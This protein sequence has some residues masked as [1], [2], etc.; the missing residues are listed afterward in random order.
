MIMSGGHFDYKQCLFIDIAYKIQSLIDDN[1]G[2]NQYGDTIGRGYRSQTIE[3]F[4]NTIKML[5]QLYA[6]IN[7]IDYLVSGDDSEEDFHRKIEE[8][9][10]GN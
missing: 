8:E 2:L 3:K 4:D 5:K 6:R 7:R 1:K 10:K 9:L